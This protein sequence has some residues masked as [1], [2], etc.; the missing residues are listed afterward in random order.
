MMGYVGGYFRMATV[1]LFAV[2]IAMDVTSLFLSKWRVVSDHGI[3]R[4][5]WKQCVEHDGHQKCSS[6][7]QTDAENVVIAFLVLCTIFKFPSFILAMVKHLRFKNCRVPLTVATA[8]AG[9]L[10]MV[11]IIVYAAS[12]PDFDQAELSSHGL[13]FELSIGNVILT[14]VLAFAC[15]HVFATKELLDNPPT[16]P[17][18]TS[19]QSSSPVAVR[20]VF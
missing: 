16:V 6:I 19:T 14:F 3:Y 7:E 12:K 11:A 20:M 1:A 17:T 15:W 8:F 18:S 10:T 9:T 2:S 5:L 4:G 13:S